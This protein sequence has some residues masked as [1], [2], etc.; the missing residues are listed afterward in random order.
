MARTI[1]HRVGRGKTRSILCGLATGQRVIVDDVAIVILCEEGA[2]GRGVGGADVYLDQ[3]EA[4]DEVK[5]DELI[6]LMVG[7]KVTNI[8]PKSDV[9]VGEEVFRAEGLCGNGFNNVSFSV[10]AGE[11]LGFSG[12][13]GSGRSETMHTTSSSCVIFAAYACLQM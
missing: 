2:G 9:P 12:L 5:R 13:V 11:I 10:R 1:A 7:R 4:I 3:A 6:T 8:Y